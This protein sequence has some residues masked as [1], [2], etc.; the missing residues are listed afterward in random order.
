ML[1]RIFL[2]YCNHCNIRYCNF[3]IIVTFA[4]T[5]HYCFTVCILSLSKQRFCFV[6]WFCGGTLVG[7]VLFNFTADFEPTSLTLTR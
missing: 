3:L 2:N 1:Q 7:S 4:L 5:V 6:Q